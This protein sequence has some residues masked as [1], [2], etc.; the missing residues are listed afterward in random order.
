MAGAHRAGHDAG[1][2]Q[3]DRSDG[4]LPFVPR[5]A[6]SSATTSTATRAAGP[7]SR[8]TAP[9]PRAPGFAWLDAAARDLRLR[10]VAPDRPG[11]GTS[12]QWTRR[13]VRVV[14]Y[15]PELVGFADALGLEH[16]S[17][18]GYSGGAPYALAAAHALGD[19]VDAIAVVAGAGNVGVWATRRRTSSCTDRQLTLLSVR[20]PVLAHATISVSAL[21]ARVLPSLSFRFALRELSVPD[22]RVVKQ[23]PSERDALVL[24][25]EAVHARNTRRRRRLRGPIAAVGIR[26]RRDPRAAAVLAR[27]RRSHRAPAPQ[28]RARRPCARARSSS[29][30]KATATSRSSNAVGEV[31]AGARRPLRGSRPG[32]STDLSAA[33][34]VGRATI[35][36]RSA[37]GAC[38]GA[39]R[40]AR[41]RRDDVHP[42][43]TP[44]TPP[45]Y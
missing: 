10:V 11:I 36:A 30:G 44:V 31:L 38:T 3:G 7:S 8:C 21:F 9:P 18:L 45:L 1:R 39:R 34:R 14:D 41:C 33:L 37:E 17:L 35:R 22:Q 28:R 15:P 23:F 6:A 16:F 4:A 32:D 20:A 40:G 5:P 2:D 26:G 12:D 27:H 25:T 42:A 29:A 19:R 24:F 43:Q 13:D